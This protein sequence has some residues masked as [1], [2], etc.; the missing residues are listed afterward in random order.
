V[1]EYN[2]QFRANYS[3][4][5]VALQ[6]TK[7]SLSSLSL[8]G[9]LSVD[10]IENIKDT[11]SNN[12]K[13]STAWEGFAKEVDDIKESAIGAKFP[14]LTLKNPE[15]NTIKLSDYVGKGKY[16]LLNFWASWCGPCR[17]DIPHLQEVYNLYHPEGFEIISISMDENK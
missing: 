10:D 16:V 13:S 5:Y 9:S 6:V 1:I 11:F 15:G 7:E 8:G 12:I 17:A 2:H 4:S 3:N 14:N